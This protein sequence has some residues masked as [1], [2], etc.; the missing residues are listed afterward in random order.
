MS[1]IVSGLVMPSA[2]FALMALPSS[3]A[4]HAALAWFCTFAA[5]CQPFIGHT[6]RLWWFL[7]PGLYSI[8]KLDNISL[9]RDHPALTTLAHLNPLAVLFESYRAVIYGTG[10]GGPPHAPDLAPLIALFAVSIVLIALASVFFKRLE[11]TFA[12]VL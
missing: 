11:P 2:S 7:S 6:L 4:S 10:D 12:K 8:E 1:P 9:F 5:E 3:A